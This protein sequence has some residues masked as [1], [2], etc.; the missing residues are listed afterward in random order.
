MVR[1]T[2]AESRSTF[3]VVNET[4]QPVE[5]LLTVSRDAPGT[6]G[7]QIEDGLRRAIR[8]G[9]LHV[10]AQVPSTR[11]LA[12]QLGVSR[13]IAVDA[14]AQ[15]AAEGYLTL[16]QGA[17]PRVSETPAVAGA[18]EVAAPRPAPPRFDFR[19][20]VP[21]VSAFPRD[22]WM[23][24]LREA[25]RSITDFELGHGTPEGVEELR[26]ALADYLGR[27]RGVVADAD[28]VIVTSGYS[29]GLALV[30]RALAGRGGRAVA[31]EDPSN[32]EQRAIVARAGLEPVPVPVDD[33][34]VVVD[35]L[36]RA[37]AV[38]VTP[39][40]QHP[41]GVLM[42]PGRRAA[43]C[44]WL[45]ERD[46]IA[47]EDDYDAEYRYDRAAVGALQGLEPER[48]V[49]A[50]SAS[51]TL[52]PA[53]R[54]GWLAVPAALMEAVRDEKALADRGT[55]RI[56]QLAFA[57]FLAR[58]E[59]DRH[60]RRMRARYRA[61][62]DAMISALAEELPE[63]EVLGIAAGLH[64]TVRL[65]GDEAAVREEAARRRI[66]LETMRDFRP[67]EDD[68]MVTLMLGYAAVPEPAIRAGVRELAA[69]IR[70]PGTRPR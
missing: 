9:S 39:A 27:V 45:R 41:T 65:P 67:P 49:Y 23:R 43:L 50:G 30:C 5:L 55:P 14:Y 1:F 20:S 19:P 36:G 28:R 3:A 22:A 32:I 29:Q 24:S 21:D 42:A 15:L 62:R 47:I 18:R 68:G 8:E 12:R 25:V 17:R 63:A 26:S 58:G 54:L 69:A 6:L 51:K 16:R 31:I 35:A 37:D 61:R 59:L 66:A 44:A 2:G 34:G 7:S 10:G 70:L 46:A 40:H 38:V 53:L 56:D 52:A 60:L 48:V 11:D 64:V 57:D 13:R 4:S 33:G